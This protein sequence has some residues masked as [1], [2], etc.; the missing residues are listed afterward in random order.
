MRKTWKSA[1]SFV[2][3]AAM[4]LTAGVVAPNVKSDAADDPLFTATLN[5]NGAIWGWGQAPAGSVV[6]VDVTEPGDYTISVPASADFTNNSG[7]MWLETTLTALPT[8]YSVVGKTIKVGDESYD[9]SKAEL[10]IE[11][12][13]ARINIWNQW[14]ATATS[15]PLANEVIS[16]ASGNTVEVTFTVVG[17]A[18]PTPTPEATPTPTPDD[19]TPTP[20]VDDPTPTP[21]APAGPWFTAQIAN[22]GGFWGWEG[23]GAPAAD[24]IASVEVTGYG[25]Y[26]LRATATTEYATDANAVWITTDLT[27]VPTDY[28]VVGKTI[29]FNDESY[30]W[31]KGNMYKDET[32]VRLGVWN[33][34]NNSDAAANPLGDNIIEGVAGDIIEMTFVVKENDTTTVTPTPVPSPTPVPP[35]TEVEGPKKD[36]TFTSGSLKYKV[37]KA[38]TITGTKRTAGAVTVVGL[39]KKNAASVNVKNTAKSGNASYKVTA[40]GKK[41]FQKA[42][43]LKKVTLGS[44]IKTIPASAFNGCKKL[45]TVKATGAK[46]IDASAFK[47]CKA[48]KSVTFAKL[49]S[50][51]KGAFKGCKKTIKVG[52]KKAVKKA[53]VKK[54]KKSGYKKF[55]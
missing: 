1:L 3:S 34:W 32:N 2:L 7:A 48:L 8:G 30:D 21:E 13:K 35:T 4:V 14:N 28:T 51:K 10:V 53:N 6:S 15:N 5:A 42:A 23:E 11:S 50:V 41:A 27:E 26:T 36:A 55:K 52:G 16:G 9:W 54:L 46:K 25:E 38:A 22:N 24:D 29:K 49:S 43:K 17:A 47:G 31:S 18:T 37:T 44:A 40:V 39:A 12:S 33:G 20:G 45:T 19:A